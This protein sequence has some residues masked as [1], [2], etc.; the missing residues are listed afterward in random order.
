MKKSTLNSGLI[1]AGIGGLATLLVTLFR[2]WDFGWDQHSQ[3]A[4]CWF[5]F[6]MN[7]DGP[8]IVVG[9]ALGILEGASTWQWD[10]LAMAL[11][12]LICFPAG[13]L[14]GLLV[15]LGSR[16]LTSKRRFPTR[17]GWAL[18]FAPIALLWIVALCVFPAAACGAFLD[19]EFTRFAGRLLGL[20]ILS[21]VL[22]GLVCCRP[23]GPVQVAEPGASA[24]GGPAAPSGDLGAAEGP[25]S[26]S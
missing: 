17:L 12:A 20:I 9:R 16:W 8:S 25:P 3:L 7:V 4:R 6:G 15:H 21:L 13:A 2:S 26:L 1:F 10:S 14:V 24:N 19:A 18:L 23:F 22:Y 5:W 11:N